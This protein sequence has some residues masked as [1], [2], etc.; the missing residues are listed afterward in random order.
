MLF[1]RHAEESADRDRLSNKFPALARSPALSRK[2]GVMRSNHSSGVR[3]G[4]TRIRFRS[5]CRCRIDGVLH[6]V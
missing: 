2:L 1:G 5:L 3:E 6:A 4:A